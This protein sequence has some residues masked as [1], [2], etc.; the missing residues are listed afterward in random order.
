MKK[1][2]INVSY[3]TILRGILNPSELRLLEKQKKYLGDIGE[4]SKDENE[5]QTEPQKV[6]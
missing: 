4:K 3:D 2:G 1:T 6:D 5:G